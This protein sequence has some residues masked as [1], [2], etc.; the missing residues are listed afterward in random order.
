[1][2]VLVE[3]PLGDPG[4][5]PHHYASPVFGYMLEGERIFEGEGEGVVR[6]GEAF[7]EPAAIGDRK[8]TA[9]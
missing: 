1:M 3:S 9:G 7:A 4:T 2:T 6:A 8:P 5:P